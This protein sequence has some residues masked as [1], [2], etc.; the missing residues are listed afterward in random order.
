MTKELKAKTND[1]L[2]KALSESREALR[3]FRFAKEG[4][5]ARNVREGRNTR[6]GIARVMT[7]LNKRAKTATK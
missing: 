6:R 7:E 1:D 4:S 2:M 3:A 5:K